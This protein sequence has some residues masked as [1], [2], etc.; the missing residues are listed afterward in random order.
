MARSTPE[1]AT[2]RAFPSQLRPGDLATDELGNEWE[3]VRV[4]AYQAGK[5]HEV[6]MQKPGNPSTTSTSIWPAH[7]R[8]TVKRRS[9]GKAAATRSTGRT[10]LVVRDGDGQLVYRFTLPCDPVADPDYLAAL[11]AGQRVAAIACE[12]AGTA[13]L[14]YAKSLGELREWAARVRGGDGTT[15]TSAS[16]LCDVHATARGGCRLLHTPAV[17]SMLAQRVQHRAP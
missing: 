5:M 10:E 12:R 11:V 7:Q 6:K 13:Q 15:V 1:A 17:D 8:L 14:F 16:P 2:E 3:V 9:D 4:A